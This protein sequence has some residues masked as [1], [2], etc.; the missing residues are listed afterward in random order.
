VSAGPDIV[1][2]GRDAVAWS[3]GAAYQGSI[4]AARGL[5]DRPN[6]ADVPFTV[7]AFF[8]GQAARMRMGVDVYR[9]PGILFARPVPPK[10]A[11]VA[12]VTEK[13]AFAANVTSRWALCVILDCSNSMTTKDAKDVQRIDRAR[14][15]LDRVLAQLPDGVQLS[16]IAYSAKG[17][18]ETEAEKHMFRGGIRTVW[19]RAPWSRDDRPALMRKVKALVPEANTPLIRSL[20]SARDELPE[21]FKK[22][23]A[24]VAITDGGDYSFYRSQLDPAFT[25]KKLPDVDADI[26]K[27]LKDR[28]IK[29]FLRHYF[30][31]AYADVKVNVIGFEVSGGDPWEVKAHKEL[32]EGL[33]AIGGTYDDAK[34]TDELV[35]KLT[36]NL[37][38]LEFEI[39]EGDRVGRSDLPALRGDITRHDGTTRENLSWLAVREPGEHSLI[40]P[41]IGRVKQRLLTHPGDALVLEMVPGRGEFGFRRWMYIRSEARRLGFRR[42]AKPASDWYLGAVQNYQ[43]GNGPLVAMA[44]LEKQ[45]KTADKTSHLQMVHPS[46]VWFE[47]GQMRAAKG[48]ETPVFVPEKV[49]RAAS[50][51]NYPA[52]AFGLEVPG[53]PVDR[54][55]TLWAWWYEG[56]RPVAAT[57][58]MRDGKLLTDLREEPLD[59]EGGADRSLVVES[60]VLEKSC[61]VPYR[62]DGKEDTA[63]EDCLVVRLRYDPKEGPYFAEAGPDRWPGGQA[64]RFFDKAGKSTSIFW[65]VKKGDLAALK[66]QLRVYSV[67]T[68]KAKGM[69]RDLYLGAPNNGSERPAEIKY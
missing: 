16:V 17:M 6:R 68:L 28:T 47:M 30:G 51:Y 10:R 36:R 33:P 45:L 26:K 57:K 12:L 14:Q 65:P 49:I 69:Q 43:A 53:W 39:D 34:N 56:S 61:L 66:Q 38:R 64:Y 50:L 25:K 35:R 55:A 42:E 32:K 37:M 60:V 62:N 31:G 15:A 1:A 29:G 46:W 44:T 40:V 19:K 11:S 54:P 5:Y 9:E 3:L 63:V 20:L 7:E 59:T 13:E 2:P 21:E 48:G 18:Q 67:A 22:R 27:G 23:R 52:P 4:K 41:L 24:I 58:V 8:R